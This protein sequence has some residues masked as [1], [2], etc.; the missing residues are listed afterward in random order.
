VDSL[1]FVGSSVGTIS[2]AQVRYGGYGTSN[3]AFGELSVN[4]DG[5]VSID[6]SSITSSQTAGVEVGGGAAS[7]SATTASNNG[8]G[9]AVSNAA[10]SVSNDSNVSSNTDKGFYFSLVNVGTLPAASSIVASIEYMEQNVGASYVY[11][12]R[13]LSVQPVAGASLP[14]RR[15][16]PSEWW[17]TRKTPEL[18]PY[19]GDVQI[20]NR[21]RRDDLG[22]VIRRYFNGTLYGFAKDVD[23][24]SPFTPDRNR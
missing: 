15:L 22:R 20:G 6:H 17:M 8:V 14:E 21:M 13:Y 19:V 18:R 23:S 10:V 5:G 11:V 3:L 12:R 9:V 24:E 7:L 2:Y 16:A 4:D 1:K